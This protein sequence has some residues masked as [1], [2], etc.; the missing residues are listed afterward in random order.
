MFVMIFS[1]PPD[2]KPERRYHHEMRDRARK[3]GRKVRE[4]GGR[5]WC[6]KT[7]CPKD[8]RRL[9]PRPFNSVVHTALIADA[10]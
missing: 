7:A 3:S 5:G 9:R 10:G 6:D 8:A 1:G 4:V 2:V